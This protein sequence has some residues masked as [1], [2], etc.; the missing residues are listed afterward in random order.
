MGGED[1]ARLVRR[2]QYLDPT[3]AATNLFRRNR[4]TSAVEKPNDFPWVAS[5]AKVSGD[6][7]LAEIPRFVV[8]NGSEP[9]SVVRFQLTAT[10]GGPTTIKLNGVEGLSIYVGETSVE[11]KSETA[12][13]V[14]TGPTT[15]TVVVDRAKRKA[16]VK[17]ELVDVAG[18]PARVAAVGGK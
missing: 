16:D 12:F 13:E 4:V 14:K 18:S 15:V 7:P 5:Y 3:P 11:A 1:A 9:L 2:W 10:V 6:L 17:C 8:W